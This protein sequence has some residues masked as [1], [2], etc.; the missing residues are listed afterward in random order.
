MIAPLHNHSHYSALDFNPELCYT[1]M[2]MDKNLKAYTCDHCGQTFKSG[3][4]LALHMRW[5]NGT[6]GKTG[7]YSVEGLAAR[8][9]SI[10]A[11]QPWLKAAKRM[12]QL[13]EIKTCP[14]G[15]EFEV[16]PSQ[17]HRQYC[18]RACVDHYRQTTD[19]QRKA[20]S[21]AQRQRYANDP[22]ANPFYGRT[23]TNYQGWGHGGFCEELGFAIRSTWEREYLCALQR[24]G[25]GFEYEPKRYDLRLGRGTY[26]PD[27]RLGGYN[28]FVEITGWD[29]PGKAIKRDLFREVYGWPLHLWDKKPTAAHIV[30]FVMMCKDV[31]QAHDYPTS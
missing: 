3:A 6:T 26:M 9:A 27:I 28:V 7:K 16:Y 5:V 25:I 8:Q 30:E 23:P 18:S 31:M 15:K 12:P 17:S 21:N 11:T 10:K 14:C 2:Y 19:A 20:I 13:K 29:K 4:G 22:T 24:A 1:A